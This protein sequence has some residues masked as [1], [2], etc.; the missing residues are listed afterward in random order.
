MFKRLAEQHRQLVKDLV[1]DLQ[2]LAIALENQGYL[3]F[4]RLLLA[5]FTQGQ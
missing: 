2:A 1:M 3:Y 5:F 4:A